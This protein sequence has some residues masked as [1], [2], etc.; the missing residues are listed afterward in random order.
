MQKIFISF[1][2]LLLLASCASN[3]D[4][5]HWQGQK[6]GTLIQEYG[7]PDTFLRLDDGNKIVEYDRSS[8]NKLAAN[9]CSLTFFIDRANYIK[10]AKAHGNGSNCLG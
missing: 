1:I 4:V 8:T 6:L 5:S 2:A 7:K 9:I 3:G 10:G